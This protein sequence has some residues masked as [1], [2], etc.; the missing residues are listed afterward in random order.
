VLRLLVSFLVAAAS[1]SAATGG[2][3]TVANPRF[4]GSPFVRTW[5]AEDYNAAP[6]NY[7]VLQ[8]PRSGFIYAGNNFGVLEFD[9]ATWQLIE[10]PNAGYG[11][12]LVIDARGR[13]WVAGNDEIAI[14]QADGRGVLHAQSVL[15]RL[16]AGERSFGAPLYVAAAPDGVYFATLT[17]IFFFGLDGGT[18][19][20]SP[21]RIYGLTWLN[22]AAHIGG[23]RGLLRLDGDK[24][25]SVISSGDVDGDRI[26]RSSRFHIFAAQAAAG[27]GWRLLTPRG[28]M[29]WAGAGA[30]LEPVG[31]DA[32]KQFKSEQAESAVFL[33]DGRCAFGTVLSGVF[34]FDRAGQLLQR[35]DRV[36]GLL[37]NRIEQLCEDA[38]GGLWIAQRGGLARVQ[39]DSPFAKHGLPQGLEGNPRAMLRHAGRLYLAHNEGAAWR[40]DATGQFTA[41]AGLPAGINRFAAVGSTLLGTGSALYEIKPDGE[42]VG[43]VRRVMTPLV[44]VPSGTE[45]GAVPWLIGG[46]TAN[47]FAFRPAPPTWRLEGPL[48][49]LRAGAASLLPTPEGFVWAASNDGRIWR[50]DLRD[51]VKL[52]APVAAYGPA[53]GVP[54]VRRRDAV[55]LFRLGD[56]V[57]ATSA[58]WLLRY[59]RTTDRFVPETRISGLPSHEG[60]AKVDIDSQGS[61][62][63]QLG[64]P[65]RQ[66]L[67]VI[68]DGA[69]HWRAEPLPSA[70]LGGLVPNTIYHDEVAHTLWVS[71][72]GGLVSVD[73]DWHPARTAAELRVLVRRV[74]TNAGEMIAVRRAAG[75]ALPR[76]LAPGQSSL[77]FEFAAPSYQSYFRGRSHVEYRSRLVG[78]E[79]GWT[80]WS[81]QTT[82]EFVRLPHRDFRFEVQARDAEGRLSTADSYAFTIAAPWWLAG[83]A[84]V[85]YVALAGASVTGFVKL[86]TRALHRR[87]AELETTVATRT[88]ELAQS[89]LQLASSNAELARLHKLELDEKTAAQ[90]AEE[91]ARLELLRY[92]LNPHFLLNA[93]TTLR[94]VV[95]SSPE[96]AGK[97]VE[98]LAEFCRLALTRTDDAGASVTDEARVIASYLETEKARWGDDLHIELAVDPAIADRRLPP[99][100]IQPLVENAIKYGGRTSTGLLQLRVAI[101]LAKGDPAATWARDGLVIEVANTGEW[102]EADSP[103]RAGSTGLGHENLRQRL[104]RYYPER[105]EFTTRVEDG[106]VIVRLVLGALIVR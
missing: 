104:R 32:L 7:D 70:A 88:H 53:Q 93:F 47:V 71:T 31:T 46:S 59:D 61:L 41:I 76:P 57:L 58:A 105:H 69:N 34:V 45:P 99:F 42:A 86:R 6:V 89:N 54:T 20:W 37:G 67:R 25:V 66:M 44:S 35:L 19:V 62:W 13:L 65:T 28:P 3:T 64:P 101:S 43:L 103:H 24:I 96:T 51:G 74:A 87:A 9:G 72:Q 73:L 95:F 30:P 82:R 55:A 22:G 49:Q 39:L 102:V 50:I 4:T 81:P 79:D 63:L 94:S 91:K 12:L 80:D 10:M 11:R 38:E 26:G 5:T 36:Q 48:T 92:Q 75:P 52:D 18:Q 97:M 83:W 17:K 16:P 90:L 23:E 100:L 40:D 2:A 68:A 85:G 21:E 1:A 60:A 77:R 8:D 106:W 84:L 15:D 33:A 14:L 98:R 56:D 78:L 29:Y 27:G